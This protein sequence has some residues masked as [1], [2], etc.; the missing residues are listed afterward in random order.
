MLGILNYKRSQNEEYASWFRQSETARSTRSTEQYFMYVPQ[1]HSEHCKQCIK[2]RGPT[3]WNDIGL[4][5]RFKSYD[6]FKITFKS[7]L[8]SS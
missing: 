3:V 6:M 8:L 1:I 7:N 2:Y 5:I 4:N